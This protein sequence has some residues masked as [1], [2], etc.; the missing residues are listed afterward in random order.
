MEGPPGVEG[1]SYERGFFPEWSLGRAGRYQTWL[2]PSNGVSTVASRGSIAI[3]RAAGRASS[4]T[5]VREEDA[6]CIL[7]L[8]IASGLSDK[9][10]GR[11]YMQFALNCNRN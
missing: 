5:D 11:Q 6:L 4:S 1:R 8:C 9:F 10:S 7:V 2:L 3:Y